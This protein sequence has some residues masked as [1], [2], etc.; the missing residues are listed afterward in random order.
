LSDVKGAPWAHVF[1][2]VA[3]RRLGRS[4]G[5]DPLPFKTCHWNCVYCQLGRT[6]PLRAERGDHVPVDTVVDEVR[7]ALAFH[8]GTGIDWITFAGS[9]E[10]TLHSGLGRMIRRVKALTSIPVG[11][12]TS[13]ALLFR[14]EVRRDL[15]PA[16]AVMPSLDAGTDRTYRAVNRPWP[17]LTFDRLVAGLVAFRA[18]YPRRLWVEV[19]L[20]R[21]LNDS[22]HELEAMA[23]VLRRVRPDR[24]HLNVPTRPPAEPWVRPPDPE[25]LARA[26]AILGATVPDATRGLEGG[27]AAPSAAPHDLVGHLIEMVTRH[28]LS[29]EEVRQEVALWAPGRV[30]ALLA[31]VRATGRIRAV[32]RHGRHFWAHA[33]ARFP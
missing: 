11:V 20:V 12:L 27:P 8:A 32:T 23:A 24:V 9:G 31:E 21:G 15:L 2:P 7:A 22:D 25:R 1:G 5:V 3:S 14:E 6:T 13:G 28:P 4:L 10:P 19:M 26:A 16:D 17:G 30:E 33:A 29:D 18:A